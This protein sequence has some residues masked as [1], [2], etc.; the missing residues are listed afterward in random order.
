MPRKPTVPSIPEKQTGPTKPKQ[1][2]VV[3]KHKPDP[4]AEQFDL[5]S[6]FGASW[7]LNPLAKDRQRRGSRSRS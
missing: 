7:E 1:P 6:A 2:R 4:S 5:W 3:A